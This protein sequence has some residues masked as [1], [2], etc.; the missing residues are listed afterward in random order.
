[1]D[2]CFVLLSSTDDDAVLPQPTKNALSTTDTIK[3]FVR[4]FLFMGE[5]PFARNLFLNG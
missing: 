1:M 4:E 5:A 3:P 2:V